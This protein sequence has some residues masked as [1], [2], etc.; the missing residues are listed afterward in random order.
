MH[1]HTSVR[2]DAAPPGDPGSDAIVDLVGVRRMFGPATGLAALT[3]SVP[4][5]SVT[6]LVGPNGAGKTTALRV[7]TGALKTEAGTARVFGIDPA[8]PDGEQVRLRCG[9]VAAKPALYDR[10][11]GRDN[12]RYAAELFGMGRDASVEDAADRFGIHDALDLRVGG[13]STGMKTRLALARAVLH[14]PDLLLLDEPTSGLDPESAHAVLALVDGMAADGKTVVM[15]THL[16]LE[17][18]GLA[19]EV[20]MMEDGKAVMAGRPEEL[21]LQFWPHPMVVFGAEVR[22]QPRPPPA[23]ARRALLHPGRRLEPGRDPGRRPGPGAGAG[24]VHGRGRRPPDQGRPPTS[25]RWRSSTSGC[26]SGERRFWSNSVPPMSLSLQNPGPAVNRARMWAVARNDLRQLAKSPDFWAPMVVLAALFF[27]VIPVI[28][29]LT[30]SNLGD[31]GTVAKVSAA[32]DLLPQKAQEA[33]QGA[34]AA[35]QTSYALAVYLFAPLAVIV[36]MTIST[37]IGANTVVGEKEKGTGEF[38]AHSPASE[39]EI[40]LGKLVASLVP[41]YLTT[42]IGFG[43]YSLAVNLIVGPNV[44]GWFFPTRAWWILMLWVVPPFLAITLSVVLRLSARVK[45]AA[46]AQQAS[47]L[48]TL[49]L[50]VLSYGQSTGSLLGAGNSGLILGAV[51]WAIAILGLM[52]GAKAVTRARLLGI[53]T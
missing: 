11:T 2:D 31:I 41:G 17:A 6:V 24:R 30:I 19:D 29:L 44:G 48:V 25:P 47:G 36:P 40:Y 28:L 34:S 23:H 37:A 26:A 50:I 14:D 39:R 38:L 9:V 51:A 43:M 52:R 49:P 5:G 4:A 13:Y 16:L 3:L 32:L 1:T 27:V 8:G 10:L 42:L 7:I 15:C 20:V 45:S 35:D 18:E 12:L 46:A 53:D 33:V 22:R 21:M